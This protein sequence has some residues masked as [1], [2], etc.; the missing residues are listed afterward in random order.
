MG[1]RSTKPDDSNSGSAVLPK[2]TLRSVFGDAVKIAI[3]TIICLLI[4]EAGIRAV[5]RIRNSRVEY[6]LLPYMVRNFAPTPP[7]VGGL[8]ILEPDDELMWVGRPHAQ[9]K[10]LD[11][12]CPMKSEDQRKAML[13]RLSPSVPDEFR[14]NPSWK[15]A[16][17]SDGFPAG[18]WISNQRGRIRD[19]GPGC[20]GRSDQDRKIS[21]ARSPVMGLSGTA[22]VRIQAFRVQALACVLGTGN[23]KVGL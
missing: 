18:R 8:R 3:G 22:I 5:Y 4:V 23:L 1:N 14:N 19:Y 15:V 17:N 9:Q 7:W 20:M 11:L 12:L 10:Y 13:S 21:V 16:L 2:R 6:V